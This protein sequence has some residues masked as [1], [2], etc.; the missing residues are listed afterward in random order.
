M[1]RPALSTFLLEGAIVVGGGI[2]TWKKIE[3][4]WTGGGESPVLPHLYLGSHHCCWWRQ[5]HDLAGARIWIRLPFVGAI[6]VGSGIVT[7]KERGRIWT[8]SDKSPGPP[9]LPL[10]RHNCC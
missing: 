7:W 6:C 4:R 1:I 10:S 2:V 3:W 5:H 9:H 8:V